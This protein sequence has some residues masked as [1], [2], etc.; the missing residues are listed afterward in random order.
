MAGFEGFELL[1]PV[2]GR[3]VYLVYTRWE[4]DEAFEAWVNSDAFRRGHAAHREGGP[5]GSAS[6][7]WTFDVVERIAPAG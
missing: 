1:R 7:L 4:S 6:E 3:D 5:V 2:D